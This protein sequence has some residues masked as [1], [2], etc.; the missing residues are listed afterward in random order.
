MYLNIGMTVKATFNTSTTITDEFG[1]FNQ[2]RI[3]QL[4]Y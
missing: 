1:C 4:S 2:I 3:Y